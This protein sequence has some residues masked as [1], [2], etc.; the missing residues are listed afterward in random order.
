MSRRIACTTLAAMVFAGVLSVSGAAPSPAGSSPVFVDMTWNLGVDAA[1]RITHLATDDTHL[2]MLHER[3]EKD[4]R[5][6]KI[7]PGK[8][9][10]VPAATESKL[11]L[12]LRIDAQA[13]GNYRVSLAGASTG[14]GYA[15]QTA[16]KCPENAAAG[17]RQGLDVLKVGYDEAGRVKDV[18]PFA[19]APQADAAFVRSATN[20]VKTWTFEPEIVGGHSRSS[21]ALVP[22]CFRIAAPGVPEV[23]CNWKL[24]GN[25][26]GTGEGMFALDPAARLES[27]VIGR[28]L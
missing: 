10:G 19:Q 9:D 20:A 22:V 21:T 25:A 28:T 13:D 2:K 3:L 16:P 1:G 11:H 17:R 7:S 23:D 6:W 15:R 5:S 14:G 24:P 18:E 8:V 12:S 27:D 4:I 26:S